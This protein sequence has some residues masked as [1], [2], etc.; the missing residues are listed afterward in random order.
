VE[1][2]E[3]EL[4]GGGVERRYRKLRP[5]VEATPWG[6]LS[7]ADQ[8]PTVVLVARRSS[9]LAA[10]QEH[11]PGTFHRV[12]RRLPGADAA[13]RGSAAETLARV[14]PHSSRQRVRCGD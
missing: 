11:P 13:L 8:D 7:V 2:S 14:A 1:L 4:Y 10:F 6:T 5:E 12:D 9:T 3:L